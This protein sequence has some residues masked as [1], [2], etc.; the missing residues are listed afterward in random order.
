MDTAEEKIPEIL[1]RLGSKAH[2]RHDRSNCPSEESLAVFLNGDLAGA[3]RDQLETHLAQCAAC[4][5]DLVAAYQ[6]A[7]PG[8]LGEVPQRLIEKAL[9]LVPSKGTLFDLT[10]RLFG[11]SIELIS[12]SARIIPVPVP[13]LRGEAT[14]S[15]SNTLQVEQEVGRFKVAVELDL[16][17]AGVCQVVANVRGESGEPAEG[18]RLSLNSRDR[19]QASFLTRGGVVVFDRISPGE[20]SIAVSES[21]TQVGKIRLN[22]MLEK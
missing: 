10:V 11:D 19:E 17:E 12:T 3:G 20:Y 1:R 21:G 9:A 14:P 7:Q 8:A 16:S 13:V 4:A 5:D 18:V 2:G 15:P 6:S 22:L